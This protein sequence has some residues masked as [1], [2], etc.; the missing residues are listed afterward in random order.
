MSD[1]LEGYDNS[2]S[3]KCGVVGEQNSKAENLL[4]FSSNY[5]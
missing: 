3:L 5:Y 1:L 2:R 4:V